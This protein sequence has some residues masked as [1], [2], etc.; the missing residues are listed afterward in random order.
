MRRLVIGTI[1]PVLFYAAPIW[2]T[3]VSTESLLTK[4]DS[5]I[6]KAAIQIMGLLKTTSTDAALMIA[7]LMPAD[8]VIRHQL[9][10]F[11]LRRMAYGDDI[12][13]G[14]ASEMR[15]NRATSPRDLLRFELQQI[16]KKG[17]VKAQDFLRTE[18][19]QGWSWMPGDSS[20]IKQIRYLDRSTAV[21]EVIAARQNSTALDIWT[22]TDG[23]VQG[24][25]GGAAAITYRGSYSN[26]TCHAIHSQ[27]WFSSTIMESIALTIGAKHAPRDALRVTFVS[28]SQAA[29][30]SISLC[31]NVPESSHKAIEEL[32]RLHRDGIEVRLWWVPG[33]IGC[34]ENE[35]AD[36]RAK[37]A[38]EEGAGEWLEEVPN[39]RRL[40]LTKC[41][42]YY[43]N[44]YN[45]RWD[46][47]DKGREL[48]SIM[49]QFSAS[50]AWTKNLTKREAALTA[51]LLTGHFSTG[52]YRSRFGGDYEE[53][54]CA[55]CDDID[56]AR[57]RVLT[58]A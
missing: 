7:G 32:E 54:I 36:R 42:H 15:F 34:T 4:L 22:F 41:L 16:M 14:E 21:Q 46:A 2:C 48:H 1:M 23:S 58:C 26:Y 51:Q 30:K 5:V 18:Q 47:S 10:S 39:C 43:H 31:E 40:M 55:W 24:R 57:H 3:A 53:E 49:P 27:G 20:N 37:K 9:V 56:T 33:H 17:N 6:R 25:N 35:E 50:I 44:L 45:K 8:L 38:A 12:S 19:R 13:D 52:A 11:F 28:D 29:L